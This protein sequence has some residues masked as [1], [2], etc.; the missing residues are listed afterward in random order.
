MSDYYTGEPLRIGNETQLLIDDAII[1]DRWRLTRV[2]HRPDKFAR[3]PIL[4]AD[5]PWESGMLHGA[6]VIWDQERELFRMWYLCF[7]NS[8]YHYGSG[9]VTYVCYAESEDGYNWQKP[10]TERCA[11]GEYRKNQYR[12]LRRAQSGHLFRRAG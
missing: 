4:V 7:N 1:E 5:K 12:A 6:N 3:N 11:Y 10:L 8:N 2:L 9:P